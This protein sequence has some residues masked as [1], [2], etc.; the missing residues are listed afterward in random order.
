MSE[1]NP[2]VDAYMAIIP[3]GTLAKIYKKYQQV[4]LEKMYVH[5]C[6]L[7]VK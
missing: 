5:S 7:K 1:E 3:G 2:F 4:L 6:S